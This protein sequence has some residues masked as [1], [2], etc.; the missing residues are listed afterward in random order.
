MPFYNILGT[1]SIRTCGVKC[2]DKRRAII[3]GFGSPWTLKLIQSTT[4]FWDLKLSNFITNYFLFI[5][6]YSREQLYIKYWLRTIERAAEK[7]A[8]TISGLAIVETAAIKLLANIM[9]LP[10]INGLKGVHSFKRRPPTIF[11]APTEVELSTIFFMFRPSP[12]AET[13]GP[14]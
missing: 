8:L 12:T 13:T 14:T 2:F 4:I 5:Y 3:S 9:H 11:A 7:V 1:S 10:A 6:S